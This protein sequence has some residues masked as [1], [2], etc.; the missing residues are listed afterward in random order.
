MQE[1]QELH[2]LSKALQLGLAA[3]AQKTLYRPKVT[4]L[5]DWITILQELFEVN[6]E[7]SSGQIAVPTLMAFRVQ[8]RSDLVEGK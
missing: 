8:T 7:R 4:R 2:F 6:C 3:S 5:H 1:F